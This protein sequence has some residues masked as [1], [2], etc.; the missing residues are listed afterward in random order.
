MPGPQKGRQT[1]GLMMTG[2]HST[3][4]LDVGCLGSF[5]SLDNL[6]LYWI[7]FLESAVAVPDDRGIVNEHIRAIFAPY[8]AIAFRIVEPLDSS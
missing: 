6:K 2:N 1:T 5:G 4:F 8:E 7:S 3:G